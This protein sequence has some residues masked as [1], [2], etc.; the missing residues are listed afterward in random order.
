M[1]KAKRKARTPIVIAEPTP[2]QQTQGAFH[3]V[4]MSYRR[5]PVIATMA[6]TGKLTP[7]QY[8]G[9]ARYRDVA[10]AEERSLIEDSVG[11]MMRGALGGGEAGKTPSMIRTAAELNR[12]E[13]HLGS[14]KELARAVAV[15]DTTVS[16]W[17]AAKGGTQPNGEPNRTWQQDGMKRIKIAG[18][19]LAIA[20]GY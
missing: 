20:S 8:L 9:L 19:V 17:A 4:G 10:I 16:Q 6:Q 3:R 2:E 1:A 5:I 14:D 12:L 11:K 13:E 15:D 18:D 7:R